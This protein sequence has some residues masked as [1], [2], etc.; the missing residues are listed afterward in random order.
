MKCLFVKS[1]LMSEMS[2]SKDNIYFKMAISNF[3]KQNS[4]FPRSSHKIATL[5]SAIY[6]YIYIYQPLYTSRMWHKV[7]FFNQSLIDLN[8]EFS[9]S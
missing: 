2:V 7:I 5:C 4:H 3:C 8:S 1:I 9:F 6:I